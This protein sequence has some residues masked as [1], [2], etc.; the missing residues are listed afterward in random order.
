METTPRQIDD[1]VITS[2][3]DE[4]RYLALAEAGREHESFPHA[5]TGHEVVVDAL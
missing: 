3:C 4:V 2:A 1:V 5:A